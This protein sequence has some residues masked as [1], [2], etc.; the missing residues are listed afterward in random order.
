MTVQLLLL[1]ALETPSAD[2]AVHVWATLDDGQRNEVV[3]VLAH[4]IA[5]AASA[6]P[7]ETVAILDE[8]HDDE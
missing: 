1:A 6:A 5:K 3:L 2:A 8:E 7:A 4:L